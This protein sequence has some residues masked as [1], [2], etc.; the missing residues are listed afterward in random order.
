[1]KRR[2]KVR[3]GFYRGMTDERPIRLFDVGTGDCRH[4]DALRAS[5]EFEFAGVEISLA[6]AAKARERGYAVTRGTLEDLD[7]SGLEGRFHF[8]TMYQLVEHVLDPKILFEKAF[9]LLKPGGMIVG[10]LPRLDSLEAQLF[11]RYWAG[12]HFPRHLQQFTRKCL[13]QCIESCG[14][15]Q[16]RVD[17]ALH[18]Q[19]ALSLQN[20]LVDRFHPHMKLH[21]G[22]VP[23]YSYLLLASIPFCLFEFSL[24]RGGMM[25]FSA[26]RPM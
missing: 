25:N 11:G 12:Y 19:A 1:V 14:F 3:T 4:F 13:F 9:L 2:D 7:I 18:L 8:V 24:G 26:S 5:G 6:M 23:Y 21:F 20:F 22:K 17:S 15:D 10:Q 16:V